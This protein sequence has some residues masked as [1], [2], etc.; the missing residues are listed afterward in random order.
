MAKPKKIAQLDKL[1]FSLK[2]TNQLSK[3]FYYNTYVRSYLLH[4]ADALVMSKNDLIRYKTCEGNTIKYALGLPS[5]LYS[6][7][8]MLAL[9]INTTVKTLQMHKVTLFLRLLTNVYTKK[10]ILAVL[11]SGES[12]AI[13]DSFV[14]EIIKIVNP[15]EISLNS[16]VRACSVFLQN[17]T[18]EYNNV[19]N[20]DESIEFVKELLATGNRKELVELLLAFDSQTNLID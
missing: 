14:M 5:C 10:V 18:N 4:G 17:G 13:E 3:G 16:L 1:G 12:R 6:T 9:K 8:L 15:E 20:S 11:S 2:S 19:I 7:E